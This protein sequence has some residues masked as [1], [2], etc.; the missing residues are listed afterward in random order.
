MQVCC[1]TFTLPCRP[2]YRQPSG[3]NRNPFTCKDDSVEA[4]LPPE[5]HE[6]DNV[7]KPE[8]GMPSEH[9]TR[10]SEVIAEI[11]MDA[12]VVFQ[13]IGLNELCM[14]E[15]RL[16]KIHFTLFVVTKPLKKTQAL[17]SARASTA[18]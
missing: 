13:L 4:R 7:P 11:S 16:W 9:H 10:L 2:V 14:W 18:T 15:R 17:G 8:G 3:Q 1:L 6:V 12:G 5:L